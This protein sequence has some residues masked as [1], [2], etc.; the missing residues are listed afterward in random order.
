MTFNGNPRS[1]SISPSNSNSTSNS[2]LTTNSNL[3]LKSLCK[4]FPYS[5]LFWSLFSRIRTEYREILRNLPVFSPNAQKCG[6]LR[7][8]TLFTRWVVIRPLIIIRDR[9]VIRLLIVFWQQIVTRDQ[10][11]NSN[12]NSNSISNNNSRSNSNSTPKSHLNQIVIWDQNFDHGNQG[13]I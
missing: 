13:L 11:T 9:I 8:R 12:S 7:I 5:E 1:N 10:V 3:R 6:T 2:I 4:Y